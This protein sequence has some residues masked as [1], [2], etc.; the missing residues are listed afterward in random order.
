[1]SV[2]LAVGRP[3]LGAHV[4]GRPDRHAGARQMLIRSQCAGDPEVGDKRVAAAQEDVLRL[5]VAMDDPTAVRVVEGVRHF[6]RDAQRFVDG[7]LSL[8]LQPIAQRFSLD[9]RHREPE[10]A[11]RFA[12]VVYRQDVRMLQARREHD[13][14]LEAFGAERR[15]DFGVQHLER[16]RPVVLEVVG[17]IDGRHPATTQLLVEAVTRGEG[18]P[19]T[20]D[21][22]RPIS[23]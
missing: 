23:L 7:Q 12:R 8:A 21:V 2:D 4:V 9:V 15:R 14:L 6:T 20:G 13:F 16:H 17:K 3:L 22:H 1:M 19:E 5:D 18:G 10:I 11:C